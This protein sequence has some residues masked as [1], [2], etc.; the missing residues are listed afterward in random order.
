MNCEHFF[1]FYTSNS[2]TYLHGITALLK[3]RM[4]FSGANTGIS[5]DLRGLTTDLSEV[6]RGH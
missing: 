4:I 5:E 2:L 1:D 3:F 6:A